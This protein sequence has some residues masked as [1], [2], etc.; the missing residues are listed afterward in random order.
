MTKFVTKTSGQK[1]RFNIKKFKRSLKRAGASGKIISTIAN[2]V[3]RKPEL[4]TTLNIYKYALG[5]LKQLHR[6]VATRYNLKSALYALGPSG[7]PFEHFVGQIFAAQEYSV[8][9]GETIRGNCVMH[10]V[11]VC[12][13]KEG[14]HFMVEVKFH[15]KM[16]IKSNVKV[17]LYVKARFDDI[18]KAWEKKEEG[19]EH[20][21]Q[22]WVVTNTQF[23]SDA[24]AYANCVGLKPLSWNY[25][26]DGNL[27]ELIDEYGLHPITALTLLTKRQKREFIEQGLVLCRDVEKNRKLLKQIGIDEQKIEKII[28]EAVGACELEVKK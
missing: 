8:R 24:I 13:H 2:E 1:E 5:R 19:T 14:K 23:T 6:P 22:G 15:N 26:K 21:H 20:F 3:V 28:E 27:A 10:E 7:Y 17:P 11:D 18:F 16:G 12:A 9:V 25:P 4:T